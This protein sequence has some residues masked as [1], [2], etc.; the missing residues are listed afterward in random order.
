MR[1]FSHPLFAP[2]LALAS[3][4]WGTL[5]AAFLLIA[6]GLSSP[7]V[8]TL[9][10]F[11]FG[12]D[13][14]TRVYR[15]DT[16]ILYLLQPLLFVAV[17]GFFYAEE[18]KGF[19]RRRGGRAVAVAAPLLFL[20]TSAFVVATSE[21]SASGTP[22]RSE[23]LQAPL[24]QGGR[25]PEFTLI[26][27]TGRRFALKEERGRVVAMTF[28]YTD[29]HATCP[30]LL[31]R[32]RQL[33]DRFPGEDL[34]LVAV[35]LDPSRDRVPE[36]MAHADRWSLGPRWHLVT[37]EPGAVASVL[38]AYGVQWAKLPDG[39]IAH[40]NLIQ[41]VDRRGRLAFTYRGLAHPEE[42]LTETLSFLLRERG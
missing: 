27:H 21:V 4:S 20:T 30:T 31:A 26:D 13:S 19:V 3:L 37:G 23:N 5:L 7:W 12:F 34:T 29:C 39:E 22:L 38:R 40:E 33:E 14:A 16:L 6:P 35:T 28:F 41:F 9:L 8:D 15:L 32:L 18:L 24:R 2:V 1:L 11:C 17:I 10:A 25:A 42:R 36:L